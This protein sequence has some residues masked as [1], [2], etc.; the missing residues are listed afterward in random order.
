MN[1]GFFKR[2]A[3][4][5]L[6]VIIGLFVI[7]YL[8]CVPMNIRDTLTAAAREGV[9]ITPEAATERQEIGILRLMR[10]NSHA[11]GGSW[12]LERPRLPAPQQVLSELKASTWD[13]EV[14]SRRGI[15]QSGSW[16]NRSLVYHAGLTLG[17][18]VAGFAI[19]AALGVLLAIGI[20]YNR[21]MDM[22]VM[23][24]AVISQTVPI[25]ALAPM[26]IIVLNSLG[27]QGLLPKAIISAYLSFFPVV[28]GMVKGLRAPDA[29]QLDQMTTWSAS[30]LQQLWKLRLPASVP[31]LFASLKVAIAASLVGTI[32]GELPVQR[33]GLGANI[34]S[35]S[36]YGQTAKIWASLLIA[37]VM[38]A[39]LVWLVGWL[40][41][42]TNR[43]MGAPREV[44]A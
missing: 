30:G 32:V 42:R 34:F 17:A 14:H 43:L 29:M 40:E 20:T 28:V 2:H 19:G 31:Y 21:A 37:A 13:E 4:P 24:W 6:A 35:A 33:G 22:S 3:L 15:V 44:T 39:L 27:M 26:I 12:S 11:L 1:R 16:S 41:R 9:V 8:A 36:Y 18:T 38:A 7:W 10:D 5:V 25:V 23:P